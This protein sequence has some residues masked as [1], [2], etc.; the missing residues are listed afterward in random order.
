MTSRKQRAS[1]R[2]TYDPPSCVHGFSGNG[3]GCPDCAAMVTDAAIEAF[4]ERVNCL[5]AENRVLRE[6]LAGV[7]A[8][9]ETLERCDGYTGG[10]DPNPRECN[11]ANW[12][13]PIMLRSIIAARA[14]LAQ[15]EGR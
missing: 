15:G 9:F 4:A 7:L 8:S 11:G 14:A 3:A 10:T 5:S 1:L 12:I 13:G 6:A 2:R